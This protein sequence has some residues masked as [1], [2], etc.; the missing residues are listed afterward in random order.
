M[1]KIRREFDNKKLLEFFVEFL[2]SK[3]VLDK[4]ERNLKTEANHDKATVG[5][6]NEEYIKY[7]SMDIDPEFIDVPPL[8]ACA[9]VWSETDEGFEFWCDIEDEFVKHFRENYH[10]V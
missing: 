6:L 8:I 2:K 10:E 1:K 4:F 3:N 7:G 9:F 5:E